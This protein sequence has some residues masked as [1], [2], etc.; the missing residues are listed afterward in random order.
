VAL[1]LAWLMQKPGVVAPLIG[2]ETPQQL[3][4]NLEALDITLPPETMQRID[5][6]TLP[7]VG[8]PNNF[9]RGGGPPP[10]ARPA[11]T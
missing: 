7:A 8:Y 5:A 6:A 4:E 3:V 9:G 2:P 1:S 10:G 11:Q